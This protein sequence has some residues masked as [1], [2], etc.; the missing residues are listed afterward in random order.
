MATLIESR[1]REASSFLDDP[2]R[3]ISKSK[4]MKLAAC[5]SPQLSPPAPSVSSPLV[6]NAQAGVL[7]R[8]RILFPNVNSQ[9]LEKVLEGCGNNWDSAVKHLNEIQSNS[10]PTSFGTFSQTKPHDN[11]L[12]TNGAQ[13]AELFV[14]EMMSVSD[15]NDA[16]NRAFRMLEVFEKSIAVRCATEITDKFK[17]E[18]EKLKEQFEAMVHE[19]GVLKRAVVIQH[20]R[21]KEYGNKILELEGLKQLMPQYQEKIRTLEMSNYSLSVHLKQAQQN[22]SIPGHFHPD[23]F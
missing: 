2:D 14:K 15:I 19:N 1:K 23:V 22:S 20:E 13:W 9:V 17:E 3:L 10:T 21:Q 5:L 18:H 8:L 4:R 12:P 11:D 6:D 7:D 16:K